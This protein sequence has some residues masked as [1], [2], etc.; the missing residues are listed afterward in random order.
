LYGQ[1]FFAH[2]GFEQLLSLTEEDS[3]K[4]ITLPPIESLEKPQK[5]AGKV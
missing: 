5:K 4:T 3:I 2:K 1:E